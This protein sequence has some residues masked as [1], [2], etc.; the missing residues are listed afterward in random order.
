MGGLAHNGCRTGLHHVYV[1]G[2]AMHDFGADRVGGLPWALY[3]SCAR[4]ITDRI[5]SD[6]RQ[7]PFRIPACPFEPI[8]APSCHDEPA[9]KKVRE[10]LHR[11]QEESFRVDEAKQS[12][13][14]LRHFRRE[15]S[16]NKTVLPDAIYWAL[17]AE[18][19]LVSTLARRESRGC[20][21]RDDLPTEDP[22]MHGR[23]TF[24]CFDPATDEVTASIV[25][26]DEYAAA[27][28]APREERAYVQA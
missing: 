6:R 25:S 13:Q 23:Y 15:L 20:F 18:A 5:L 8:L 3:L 21:F 17:L 28:P 2:E 4:Q 27:F 19:I 11:L 22:R 26:A 14:E 7:S 1:T 24:T 10:I 16:R 12:L 9:L